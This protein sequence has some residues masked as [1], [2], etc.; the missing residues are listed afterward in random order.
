[1]ITYMQNDTVNLDADL[2]HV[3]RRIAMLHAEEAA[4]RDGD[5][6]PRRDGESSHCASDLEQFDS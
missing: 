3:C 4:V 5:A 2:L 1:M 6:E